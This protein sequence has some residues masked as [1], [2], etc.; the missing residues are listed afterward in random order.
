MVAFLQKP[1][2][3]EEFHHIVDFL[4]DSHIRYALIA[5]PTIYVSLEQ[6]WQTTTVI[7]VNDGEQQITVTVDGHK[8][9]A[10]EAFV[11]R[12][13]QLVDIDGLSSLP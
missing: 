7:T 5:N 9:A 6:F 8:F 1:S 11:R 12:H 13:L 2:R 10:T 4:A 3:S